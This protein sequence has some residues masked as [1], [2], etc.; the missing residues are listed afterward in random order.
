MDQTR[1]LI[2]AEI[3]FNWSFQVL[4]RVLGCFV[5]ENFVVEVWSGGSASL[6]YSTNNLAP[7]HFLADYDRH[8]AQVPIP[9]S[10]TIAVIYEN[11]IAIASVRPGIEDHAVG[12]GPYSSAKRS[13]DIDP[14]VKSFFA[15]ERVHSLAKGRADFSP[16]WPNRGD[17]PA[18][19][20][21]ENLLSA[22]RVTARDDSPGHQKTEGINR[23]LI[24]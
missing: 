22:G 19:N 20:R 10:K 1:F 24:A 16:H 13:C 15:G 3:E 11:F 4:S 7:A 14:S 23:S 12:G 5:D 17:Y 2:E 8:S 9:G 21:I 18:V 6:P